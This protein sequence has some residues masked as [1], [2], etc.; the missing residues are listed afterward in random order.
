MTM[1]GSY[2]PNRTE[3]MSGMN[4]NTVH[5]KATE[6]TKGNIALGGADVGRLGSSEGRVRKKV[7][8]AWLGSTLPRRSPRTRVGESGAQPEQIK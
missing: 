3:I 4:S 1:T 6:K 2:Q 7:C 8:E 5:K